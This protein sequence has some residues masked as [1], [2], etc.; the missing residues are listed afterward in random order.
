MEISFV[1]NLDERLPIDIILI[2]VI[3]Y[4]G[5]KY[6]T[7]VANMSFGIYFAFAASILPW[8]AYWISDWR[9]L[10]VVTSFPMIVAFLSPWMVPE[11]AR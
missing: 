7:L 6:R 11:S 3:E 9:I 10:S 1:N 8:I 2:A 5:P 4:V